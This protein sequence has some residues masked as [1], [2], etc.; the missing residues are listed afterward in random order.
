MDDIKTH[1]NRNR[2]YT[3]KN[4]PLALLFPR[5]NQVE[6]TAGFFML[7][8]V[9]V[10]GARMIANRQNKY[11]VSAES[12]LGLGCGAI[13]VQNHETKKMRDKYQTELLFPGVKTPFVI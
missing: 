13:M 2:I 6:T 8:S 3:Q 10:L 4:N 1:K 5:P 9:S 12:G 7:F 11:V